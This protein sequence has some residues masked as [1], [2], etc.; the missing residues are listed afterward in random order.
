[1]IISNI[2]VI[3]S[4]II[5]IV[6]VISN[7]TYTIFTLFSFFEVMK[8]KRNYTDS[9]LERTLNESFY[10]PISLLVPAY[11]EEATIISSLTSQLNI[12][13]A[14]FEI[15]VINDG[16]SDRTLYKL[17]EHFECVST[18]RPIHPEIFHQP[19]NDIYI[20]LLYPNLLI[21]DKKNGGKFDAI[22]CG[23]N[24]SSYPLFA[25]ID[26]DSL[27]EPDSLLRAG[28]L[29]AENNKLVAIGGTV[30]PVN[31][32]VVEN[33]KVLEV[34]T[35]NRL[36]ELFQSVEYIR[37]FLIGRSAWNVFKSLLIISGA[38]GV[39][40]K[41][42]VKA[43]GGFRHTV[44]EDMDLVIRIHKYCI[45]N[46][47]K[48]D[49]LS[50]PDTICW[51]QVPGDWDSLGKQRNRWQRGLVDCLIYNRK[52]IFNPKYKAVG[53]LGLTYFL[54]VEGIGG[55]IEF[56]GYIGL[57]LIAIFGTINLQ[58]ILI[59]T[60]MMVMWSNFITMMSLFFD[61]LMY[62]RYDRVRDLIKLI[63][64]GAIENFGY[65]QFLAYHK[66]VGSIT[67][68]KSGWGAMVRKKL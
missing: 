43:V 54:F 36:I 5:F 7:T 34:K 31:G 19:V 14:E 45:D 61:N 33:G 27:L 3:L 23:I 41:D 65:R 66:F 68:W 52:M 1:M 62:R 67:F 4:A 9:M 64:I 10:R 15:V 63:F 60:L 47:M 59:L 55:F 8:R 13:Y 24:V 58:Y 35:P 56:L 49:I 39:F 17:I 12:D 32:C 46:K 18:H 51:T 48:Y 57:A 22:N 25:V 11:N 2:W 38:F 44:G 28:A 40:R 50:V 29:F 6:A 37:G 30:R 26:A 21:V 53:L 42:I 20:S 16:S